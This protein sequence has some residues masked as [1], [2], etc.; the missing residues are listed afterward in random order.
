MILT[1]ISREK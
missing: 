1:A